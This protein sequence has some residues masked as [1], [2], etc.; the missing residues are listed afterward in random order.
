MVIYVYT[1]APSFCVGDKALETIALHYEHK[2]VQIINFKRDLKFRDALVT[3]I[4][5]VKLMLP[6]P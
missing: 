2:S 1:G 3:A 5:V 4:E 6:I